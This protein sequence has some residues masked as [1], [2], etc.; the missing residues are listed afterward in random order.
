MEAN[1]KKA[2]F[3]FNRLNPFNIKRNR[4]WDREKAEFHRRKNDEKC[5][6][7]SPHLRLTA[8]YLQFARSFEPYYFLITLTFGLS[9][10]FLE[11]CQYTN[12]LLYMLN[13]KKFTDK[14][15]ARNHFLDGFAFF[16][17]HPNGK[18]DD[19]LHVHLLIKKHNRFKRKSF[20]EH[21][22]DFY[23]V[24]RKIMNGKDKPV[25][26]LKYI[27]IRDPGEERPGYC[28]ADI[29]DRNISRVK[30]LCVDGLSDNLL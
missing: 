27:D 24:A 11:R 13:R 28:M 16:E 25:F 14:F 23:K 15:K 21:I 20:T 6:S 19:K 9:T 8:Q 4:T 29:W 2:E 18:F 10:S 22:D 17:D 5:M 30:M 26:N 7:K 1:G 12:D 3:G